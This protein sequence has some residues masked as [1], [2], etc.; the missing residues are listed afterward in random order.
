[1][2]AFLSTCRYLYNSLNSL[3][4]QD[5]VGMD[6]GVCLTAMRWAVNREQRSTIPIQKLLE[7]GAHKPYAI[8]KSIQS[9]NLAVLKFLLRGEFNPQKNGHLLAMAAW[10]EGPEIVQAILEAGVHVDALGLGSQSALTIALDKGNESVVAV[11]LDWRRRGNQ[12]RVLASRFGDRQ[13]QHQYTHMLVSG[14]NINR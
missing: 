12:P 2:F 8:Q 11:L 3:F 4:Y 1:M 10:Y 5:I 13:E 7:A 6:Q 14:K 9:Q